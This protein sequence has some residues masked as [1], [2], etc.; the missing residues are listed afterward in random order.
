MSLLEINDL[1]TAYGRTRVHRGIELEL[2]VGEIAAILGPNGAGK[3]TLLSAI[4]GLI[5]PTAG[6]IRYDSEDIVGWSADRAAKAGIN[7]VPEGR[8]IFQ[9]MTVRDN[10]ELGAYVQSDRSAIEEDLERV[11]DY[12]PILRERLSYQG[13]DLSGGQQQMLAI[14]RGLMAR[15]RLMLL[16]EPSLGL[17][18]VLVKDL[19]SIILGLREQF[20]AS[21]LLVEQ[22]AS[23]A[24]AVA[25]R[26]YLMQTGTIA[27][28]GRLDE[29]RDTGLMRELYLG[30]GTAA[31]G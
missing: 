20:G 4:A 26:G 14:A 11:L 18:P 30:A 9:G 19:E 23:L 28:G 16:D 31:S 13:S 21:V 10:L 25:E 29:M 12:F 22:N 17:S 27:A 6:Q 24:L 5:R 3:S 2:D 8:R 7:L 15:P 1:H